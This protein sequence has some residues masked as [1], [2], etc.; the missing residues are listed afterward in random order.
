ML[1]VKWI[2]IMD[3]QQSV[4]ESVETSSL[5][6]EE[7]ARKLFQACDG[8]GDGYIDRWKQ[9]SLIN[10]IIYYLF[11]FRELHVPFIYFYFLVKYIHER[12]SN[13]FSRLADDNFPWI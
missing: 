4:S 11:G 9:N 12:N 13:F 2:V 5:C 8:D 7:R 6:E 1:A 3:E 10:I